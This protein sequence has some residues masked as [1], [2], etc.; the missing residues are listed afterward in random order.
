MNHDHLKD[1]MNEYLPL[2][3]VVFTTLRQAIIT[4][5]FAPGERLMEISL[6]N[7]MGVSRTPVREAIRKLELE[8]LVIMIPRKGAQVAKIT[9]KSLN[10]VI[11]VRM[12]LEE[13]AVT[14]ACERIDEDG[15]KELEEAH[16]HF[17]EAANGDDLLDIADKDEQFH[18]AIF[19][20]T[21][22]DRLINIINN[23]REQFYRYRMEYVKDIEQHSTLVTE[24]E[25]LLHAIFN[26]DAVTA[27]QIMR[28]H[29]QNQQEAVMAAIRE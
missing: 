29:L 2:R 4:G 25:Q 16:H 5:E 14:L 8:G 23:L 9:E 13:F 7:Q 18:D 10:D 24:H 17:V 22:N 21:N 27:K 11:E 6:A 1:T 20:A 12:V 26:N 28:T 3:D 19:K 15:K